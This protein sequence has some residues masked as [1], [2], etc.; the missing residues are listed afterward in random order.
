[1]AVN[2]GLGDS[3]HSLYAGAQYFI[4]GDKLKLMAGAEWAWLDH[5]SG[6]SYDGVTLFTGVRFAF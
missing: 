3:Y 1:V 4:N 6:D 2:K 5:D